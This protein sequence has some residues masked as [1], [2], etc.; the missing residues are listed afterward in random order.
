[1]QYL[2]REERLLPLTSVYNIRDLGGYETQ[3]GAYSKSHKYIRS[4][5]M[6]RL[7]EVDR[8]YLKDYGIKVIIDL[9]AILWHEKYTF[10]AIFLLN[11]NNK[12]FI[13]I[14]GKL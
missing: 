11:R 8:Q 13:Y 12:I 4:G 7:T 3:T 9:K 6:N 2:T 10:R 1:M 5:K 14:R